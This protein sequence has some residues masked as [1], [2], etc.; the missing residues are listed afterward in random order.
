MKPSPETSKI[1]AEPP[2][3]AAFLPEGVSCSACMWLIEMTLHK[4]DG[5]A[6]IRMAQASHQAT[7]EWSSARLKVSDILTSIDDIKFIAHL[8]DRTRRDA[9]EK[10]KRHRKLE[11]LLMA[12][13]MVM[14]VLDFQLADSFYE[15]ERVILRNIGLGDRLIPHSAKRCPSPDRSGTWQLTGPA[16]STSP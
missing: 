1:P 5:A 14:P 11:R 4:L 10:E 13:R 15:A 16:I 3:T 6:D 7:L 8:F 2:R 9:P 12:E